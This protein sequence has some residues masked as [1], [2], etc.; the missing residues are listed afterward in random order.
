MTDVIN[1][2]AEK[3]HTVL[4]KKILAHLKV[5]KGDFVLAEL[6]SDGTVILKPLKKESLLAKLKSPEKEDN[7][8]KERI[9]MRYI[10]P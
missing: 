7:V 8:L 5:G 3:G 2:Y 9:R 1:I 6:K 10:Q 4:R